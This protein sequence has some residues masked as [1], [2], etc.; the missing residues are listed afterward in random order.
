MPA[1]ESLLHHQIQL[2]Q[3]INCSN[4]ATIGSR[5]TPSHQRV[6]FRL[7]HSPSTGVGQVPPPPPPAGMGQV[8]PPPPPVGMGQV[9]PPPP[10]AG[11]G[12]VPPPPP[13]AGMGQVPHHR[14]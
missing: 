12:Q 6:W 7:L 2:N 8:P 9:P 1:Q 14:Q 3:G 13:P 11:M 4:N 5:T 10:P